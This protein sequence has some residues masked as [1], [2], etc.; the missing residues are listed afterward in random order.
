MS[1]IL[2]PPSTAGSNKPAVD[3]SKPTL[4]APGV[5]FRDIGD[6][7]SSRKSI[8]DGTLNAARQLPVVKN[9]RYQLAV[10]NVD[11]EDPETI[12]LAKQKKMLLRGETAAR[13]LR[14]DWVL[15]DLNGQEIERRRAT[16]ASVPY[17]TD[18]GMFIINGVQ[19]G[20]KNQLRLDPGVYTRRKENGEIESHA[21]AKPGTGVVHRYHLEPETGIFRIEFAQSNMPLLPVLRAFGVTDDEVRKR[22]GNELFEAN[23]KKAD[24][25]VI[26]KLYSKLIRA[27][28][29]KTDAE[30]AAAVVAALSKIEFDPAVNKHT[31]GSDYKNLNKDAILAITNKLLAVSR[32]ESETDNRDHMAFQQFVSPE[33][34]FA[35]RLKRPGILLHQLLWKASTSGS[36]KPIPVGAFNKHLH[37]AI[38]DSGLGLSLE[39][40]NPLEW[41]D[42]QHA[43][44]RLG[45]GG[46]ASVDS[47]PIDA[48]MVMPSHMGYLDPVKTPESMSIGVEGRAAFATRLG[49]DGRL[50]TPYFDPKTKQRVYKNAREVMN[51]T[52]AFPNEME[53]KSPLVGVLKNGEVDYVPREQVDL[54]LPKV[55]EWLSPL[56]NLVPMANASR[57]DR[58]S[59]GA[60]FL[61]QALPLAK[62]ESPLVQSQV[63]GKSGLSFAEHFG[64]RMG[65]VRAKEQP[66]VVEKVTPEEVV[67]R[68]ADGSRETHELYNSHPNNRK[69]YLHNTAVVSPGDSVKPGQL[70]AKSNFTDDNGKVAVGLNLRTA[71]VAWGGHNFEDAVVV[72]ESAARRLSSEHL[73]QQQLDFSPNQRRNKKDFVSIFASR[74]DRSI[75]NKLDDNGVVK[76]GTVVKYGE[77]LALVAEERD[78]THKSV[79]APHRGAFTDRSILW[80][81]HEDGVVTDVEVTPRGLAI[82]VKTTQPLK[83][84]DKLAGL[85]GDKGVVAKVIPDD[86]MPYDPQTKMPYELLLNPQGIITRGNPAQKFELWLSKIAAKTGNPYV[87]DDFQD[88]DMAEFVSSELEKNGLKGMETVID[89]TTGRKITAATGLRY[90]LKLHH[91]AESKGQGRGLGAYSSE[92]TPAKTGGQVGSSKR[93]SMMDI[94]SLHSSGATQV[95]R[96]ARLIRGQHDPEYWAARMSGFQPPTPKTPMVYRKFLAYLRG[97]GINVERRGSQQHLMAMTDKMVDALAENREI[98]NA[99][100]VDWKGGLKPV[101]GGLFDTKLTGGHGNENRWSFFKLHE[102]MPNPAFEEPIRHLLKLS[103]PKFEKILAGEEQFNEKTG[104]AAIYSALA[105]IDLD[106]AL[107]ACREEI[108]DSRKTVRDS[109]I[110]RLRYLH[111]LKKQGVQPKELMITKVPVL[112]PAFRPISQ[113]T[114]GQQLVSDVNFLYKEAMDAN[115]NLKELSGQVS[116]LSEE[117]KALYGA[118]KAV[119]GLGDPIQAKN[120]ERRVQGLL[121]QIIG[122]SPKFGVVQ[123]KLLGTTLDLVGRAVITPNPDLSMDEVGIPEGR[124]WDVYSPFLVGR[125]VRQGVSRAQALDYVDQR[126]PLARKALLAEME[127]RPVIISRAPLLHRFGRMAAFPRLVRGDT[128]QISPLIVAGFGAD[129]DGDTM[130]YEVVA[131]DAAADEAARKMLPSRNL[132][133]VSDLKRPMHKP[134]NEFV[135]GLYHATAKRSK[136]DPVTF[137]TVKD[138]MRALKN[139]DINAEDPVEIIDDRH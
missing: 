83:H 116:N 69:T 2:N 93:L 97:A 110:R 61:S 66:G 72:S 33:S 70:L 53:S 126:H 7:A 48:R 134:K 94:Y 51:L 25:S 32:G 128:L 112:P 131:D 45:R 15:R 44:T 139:G 43:V 101:G 52:L 75:L 119:A 9:T 20:L 88:K 121:A 118:L 60:R 102:P 18:R 73:Y 109:A 37:G 38:Q 120:K 90:Q 64:T 71:Y 28:A 80:D 78:I 77:P 39:D 127:S 130:N 1:S 82:A 63:P 105:D 34:L 106:R 30:K 81:H 89:P 86:E 138:M 56:S 57:A 14:G 87:M 58:T 10:E 55:S 122:S 133:A 68:Y 62:P 125:L 47:V 29:A 41:L 113:M 100:T 132:I 96:D 108:K 76:V 21:N 59:M 107:N 23:V 27:G 92:G 84:G 46:I 42:L 24:N 103:G 40:V 104:P 54:V 36:L 67:V 31:L 65:A 99:E 135:A 6:T 11:Y 123:R 26:T 5:T 4:L 74:F 115:K 111:G 12:S 16:L 91:Q 8:F 22:W 114:N 19:T 129:F 124:A 49:N 35:E 17:Q 50:Y 136:K 137:A 79:H 13:R 85:A 95:L 98:E 117:R 3:V